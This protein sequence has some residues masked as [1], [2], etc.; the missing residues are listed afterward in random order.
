MLESTHTHEPLLINTIGHSL[1]LLLFAGLLLLLIRDGRKGPGANR[2][3][4]PAVAA[5]VALGWNAGSL[6]VLASS[7]VFPMLADV[8]A[9]LSFG[10]LSLLPALL[11]HLSLEGRSQP[12][13]ICGYVFSGAALVLHLAELLG[14]GGE[15]LHQ[16]ALWIMIAGFGPLTLVAMFAAR[17]DTPGRGFWS[18]CVCSCWPFLLSISG[19]AG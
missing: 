17:R 15:R 4:L 11:L 7:N 5:L 14:P 8:V 13:W 12:I 16:A 10:V 3:C 1:G 2:R 19:Q 18:A 9:A 6:F